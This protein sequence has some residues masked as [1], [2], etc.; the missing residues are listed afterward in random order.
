MSD[1]P[2]TVSPSTPHHY[3]PFLN[4]WNE[5]YLVIFSTDD[6]FFNITGI[7]AA[8]FLGTLEPDHLFLSVNAPSLNP[9]YLHKYEPAR[10]VY[11]LELNKP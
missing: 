5:N 10:W 8:V 11:S 4:N 6:F 1:T 7:R 2:N 3:E 9:I